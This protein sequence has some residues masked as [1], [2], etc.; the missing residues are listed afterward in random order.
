VDEV[1]RSIVEAIEC[2]SEIVQE[3]L[4]YAF[5]S[6]GKMI[7][8]RLIALIWKCLDSPD[9]SDIVHLCSLVELE[10]TASLLHD[11]VVDEADTRRGCKSHCAYF[12]CRK[13]VLHGDYLVAM[14]V[15]RLSKLGNPEITK[16][17]AESMRELV[18]GE[19]LQVGNLSENISGYLQKSFCK[20]SALFVASLEAL[21]RLSN[22]NFVTYRKLGACIGLAFQLI[23]DALDYEASEVDLGKPAVG[24]DLSQGIFTAPFLLA[25]EEVQT[26]VLHAPSIEEAVSL[27]RSSEGVRK[28][29][30]LATGYIAEA[31]QIISDELSDG[32]DRDAVLS[33]LDALV[34][35]R[36]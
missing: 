11:D 5:F 33:L 16:A 9:V 26:A 17:V 31:K 2:E 35:R 22:R 3:S 36:H 13:S 21:A 15:D 25:S 18:R 28:T 29:K 32:P 6:P 23:D 12:G 1:R 27:V 4:Q 20:T 8:S 34:T 30:A 10:H 19:L 14:V 24:F 7:R